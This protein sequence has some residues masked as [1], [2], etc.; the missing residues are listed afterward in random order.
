VVN[1]WRVFVEFVRTCVQTSFF[2]NLDM[3]G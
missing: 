2:L 3:L 1:L